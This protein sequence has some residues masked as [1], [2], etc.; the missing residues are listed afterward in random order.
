MTIPDHGPGVRLPP[1][2]LVG[3]VLAVAWFAHLF[4]P[5]L[6]GPPLPNYGTLVLFLGIG[7]IGCSLLALVQ[8]GND[9]RPD[10]PDAAIVTTGPFRFSRNPIYL[11]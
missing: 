1:P 11:G 8:A 5:V 10:R 3:G 2:V 9:P 4:F 6:L 7:L